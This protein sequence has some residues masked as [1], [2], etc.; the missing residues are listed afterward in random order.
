MEIEIDLD[1]LSQKVKDHIVTPKT[2]WEDYVPIVE[3]DTKLEAYFYAGINVPDAYAE[4]HNKLVNLDTSKEVHLYINNGGGFSSG[5]STICEAISNCSSTVTAHLSGQV[6]SAA[7]IVTMACD[8]ITV[9]PDLMFMVH[10]ASFENMGG[11]FSDIKSFQDFYNEHA[12]QMS[13]NQYLGFLTEDEIERM[14]NGKELWFDAQEV[15]TR[16]N[17]RKEFLCKNT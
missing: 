15:L 16:W 1:E 13:R 7:T 12:R 17:N 10:E 3:T 8:N 4:F 2:V 9:T 11:K 5:A 14:H 6:A